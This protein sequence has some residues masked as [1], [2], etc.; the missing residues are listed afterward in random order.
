MTLAVILFVVAHPVR[1]R[2]PCSSSLT[3]FV[4]AHPV[5]R[6]SPC[7]SPLTLLCPDQTTYLQFL[8]NRD[9]SSLIKP[10]RS[11]SCLRRQITTC[12]PRAIQPRGYC[13]LR[14]TP[15]GPPATSQ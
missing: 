15:S 10:I 1:R 5:R 4:A 14:R 11:A 6:R 8:Y 2:S 13:S 7:S 12:L 3:L 9:N